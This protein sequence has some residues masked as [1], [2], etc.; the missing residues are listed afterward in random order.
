MRNGSDDRKTTAISLINNSLK[1]L[2]KSN[3]FRK[4]QIHSFLIDFASNDYLGLAHNKKTFKKACKRLKKERFFSPKSSQLINGYHKIH[5]KFEKLLCKLNSFERGI[6]VGSGFLANI[7]MIESLSRKG[8]LV[9]IDEEYHASG[10]V[11]T[12]LSEAEVIFFLIMIL[13]LLKIN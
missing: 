12:K 2:K 13:I 8:D 9:L 10:V 7:A 3:R 6:V 1:A 11:A 4:R 5:Q